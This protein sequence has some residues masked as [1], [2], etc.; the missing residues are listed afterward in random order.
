MTEFAEKYGPWAMVTG[1]SDGIGRAMAEDLAGRGLNLILVARRQSLLEDLA[2]RLSGAHQIKVQVVAADLGDADQV[3]RVNQ[4]GAAF[5]VGL[6]AA[7]AGFGTAG[8]MLDINAETELEV[9]D[10]NCRAVMQMTHAFGHR[11]AQRG[12]GGIVLMSSIVA[13]QGVAGSA[14]Y[15]ATKAYVQTLAEGIRPELA[16]RGVDVVA[17]APGPVATGFAAR[18]DM[19][20]SGAAAPEVVA[21]QTLDALGRRGLVR[22]GFM[23][24]F[25]GYNLAILPRFGRRMV[26][27]QVMSGMTKHQ[28][29]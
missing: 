23:S 15:A 28:K 20:M 1:A 29:A 9:I 11:L 25:L 7:C 24:K 4:A 21:R 19:V 13:F 2:T 10:V 8:D 17:S 27:R 26:M 5:D 18:A 22:P 6:L 16:K 12:R 14:N 3:E